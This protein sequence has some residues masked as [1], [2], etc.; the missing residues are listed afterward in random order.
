M[1]SSLRQDPRR[2]EI[3]IS[4]LEQDMRGLSTIGVKNQQRKDG[5]LR[6]RRDSGG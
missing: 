2:Q 5:F 3:L 6:R 4:E 1:G